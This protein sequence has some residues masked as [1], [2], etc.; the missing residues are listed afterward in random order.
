MSEAIDIQEFMNREFYIVDC[1]NFIYYP[2]VV[3][4]IGFECAYGE[5]IQFVINIYEPYC[6]DKNRKMYKSELERFKTFDEAKKYA[7]KLN[8][9]PENKQRANDWNNS[10]NQYRMFLMQEKIKIGGLDRYE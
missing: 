8:D 2:K 1:K 4:A 5:E 9:I 10:E 3:K 7:K 6:P